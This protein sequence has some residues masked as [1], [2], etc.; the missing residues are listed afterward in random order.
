MDARPGKV[1]QNRFLDL[2]SSTGSLPG[3][4]RRCFYMNSPVLYRLRATSNVIGSG[5]STSLVSLCDAR[6][7][8]HMILQ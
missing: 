7:A 2:P 5:V 6:A 8:K 4:S 1:S 3:Q